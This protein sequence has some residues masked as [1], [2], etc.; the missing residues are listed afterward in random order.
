MTEMY[1]KLQQ[2][3][4]LSVLSNAAFGF[5]FSNFSALQHFVTTIVHQTL[6]APATQQ[7]LGRGWVPVWG[8]VVFSNNPQASSV[9]ADNTM[10]LLYNTAQHLFVIAIA[11]TNIKST[12]GWFQE[13]F[14]VNAI[15]KWKDIT[16]KS[17]SAL[18]VIPAAIAEGTNTG[19]QILTRMK[20]STG[21]SMIEALSGYLP[22]VKP[23]AELAVSGHSLGGA[24]TPV[25]AL[26]L[27]DT[28]TSWNKNHI[29]K[30]I[31]AYPTAG[32]TAGN[33]AF[34]R[35]VSKNIVYESRYNNIDVVPQG[36]QKSTLARVPEF[37]A[38]YIMPPAG[39]D[40][41]NPLIGTLCTG[42]VL[43]TI[44]TSG[45]V[46]KPISYIQ[47]EPWIPMTG[48][49]DIA[50]DETIRRKFANIGMV[51]PDPLKAYI[52]YLVNFARFLAQ[53]GY[54]HLDAYHTQLGIKKFAGIYESVIAGDAPSGQSK[55]KARLEAIGKTV[56]NLTGI[57]AF[58]RLA[59]A[60]SAVLPDNSKT[61]KPAAS[62]PMAEV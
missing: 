26:Y 38:D 14:K 5:T 42:A 37:Y 19:L 40:P 61:N 18:E 31:S 41:F 3:Y 45:R 10:M 54:Q 39:A 23:G 52:P 55:A 24:L 21:M 27:K 60:E 9:V 1:S 25:M 34:A 29:V 32:P 12:Y 56:A 33:E 58:E 44:D 35:A 57:H 62:L 4:S 50:T 15:V 22:K 6:S 59:T 11:G 47:A 51:V 36:W 49:F 8:P 28:M 30:V 13:D 43:N 46:P 16:G 17:G 48:H 7:L 53:L 20:D 2:V